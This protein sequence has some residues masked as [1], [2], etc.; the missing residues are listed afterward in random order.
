MYLIRKDLLRR[1]SAIFLV[2]CVI[3]FFA[4]MAF[5][6][7]GGTYSQWKPYYWKSRA[8]ALNYKLGAMSAAFLAGSNNADRTPVAVNSVPV[9]VYHG[10][11]EKSDGVNVDLET[12]Q[13]QMLA[14]HKNG[15]HTISVN[16]LYDF[17]TG[18]KRLPRYSFLITF[19]DGRKDS[20]YAADPLLNALGYSAVMFA[21]AEY[22]NNDRNGY[23]L[24]SDEIKRMA[25]SD[26]WTIGS[27]S[28]SH[29]DLAR[30]SASDL[31]N[32]I[33]GS[34]SALEDLI[35]R[36]VE[37][38][39]FPFGDVGSNEALNQSKRT[40]RDQ[41]L[42]T[43]RMSF[44]QYLNGKRFTQN[45][46]LPGDL[47]D[48]YLVKRVSVKP[49]WSGEDLITILRAGNPKLLPYVASLDKHDGWVSTLWGD[50][51]LE[52]GR[53]IVQAL[54]DSTGSAVVLDG[55]RLWRN[56][57]FA[58]SISKL[59][60]S[61]IYL[62]ARF[63]DDNNYVACNIGLSLAHIEEVVDGK[64]HVIKGTEVIIPESTK[65]EGFNAIIRVN[66]RTVECLSN[67]VPLVS[68]EFLSR[69]LDEGGIGFKVWDSARGAAGISVTSVGVTSLEPGS[70]PAESQKSAT[71]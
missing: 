15:Y 53:L 58:A 63:K 9:L 51:R 24:D 29:R 35:R 1:R 54:P 39:A 48:H 49:E 38:F 31:P 56:Y 21:I 40:L 34:R 71:L 43:Y 50:L 2:I 70:T 64:V 36:P 68:T 33:I 44:F 45:Y 17:L 3:Y 37:T 7:Y 65:R 69:T 16:D 5:R 12:F 27:H 8:D 42:A 25:E 61:N 10:I 22:S 4:L 57:E 6:A 67:G 46:Q 14:L 19:D 23:Y 52:N 26:N 20:Y 41:A 32:E 47:G 13:D 11:L 28:Y 66:G 62:W 60:G 59:G 18:Q 30:V 55:T